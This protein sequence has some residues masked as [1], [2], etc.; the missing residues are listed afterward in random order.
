[1]TTLKQGDL[2]KDGDGHTRKVLG[3]CGEVVHLSYSG[4]A[5][6]E[7]LSSYTEV[8]LKK[9]GYT[10]DTPAWEPE[11]GGDYWFIS[12]SGQVCFCEWNDDNID[13]AHRDFLGIYQTQELAEAALLEIRR[14][15]GE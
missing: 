6:D 9:Q 1:M 11:D 12:E 15:L 14:K 5:R 2:V 7:Y 4:V 8:Q 3:K 13:H 10:W